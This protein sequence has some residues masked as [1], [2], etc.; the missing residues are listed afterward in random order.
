VDGESILTEGVGEILDGYC[1]F[2]VTEGTHTIE[3]HDNSRYA[4]ITR[5][6]EGTYTWDS[7]P[8][9]WCKGNAAVKF[10]NQ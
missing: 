9:N 1:T 4:A 10:K 7:M 5:N 2:S 3:I 6:F 8:D